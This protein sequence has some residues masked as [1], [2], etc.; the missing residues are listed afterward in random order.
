M[1]SLIEF[2][3][4][5]DTREEL[6][7]EALQGLRKEATQALTEL[8]S[9]D[10]V[11]TKVTPYA[12]QLPSALK[13]EDQS[14]QRPWSKLEASSIAHLVPIACRRAFVEAVQV[15]VIHLAETKE[16]LTSER[17][18]QLAWE[19]EN[20]IAAL[21]TFEC[22]LSRYRYLRTLVPQVVAIG[23][24]LLATIIGAWFSTT[25]GMTGNSR[26]IIFPRGPFAAPEKGVSLS[27]IPMHR[28]AF[29]RDFAYYFFTGHGRFADEYFSE[30]PKDVIK[31]N[32]KEEIAKAASDSRAAEKH[33]LQTWQLDLVNS[34]YLAS[35]FISAIEINITFKEAK[36]FPWHSINA[37]PTLEFKL[38]EVPQFV[39]PWSLDLYENL[40]DFELR[41]GGAIR[42][43]NIGEGPALGLQC[44]VVS[45]SGLLI[46]NGELD[47]LQYAD[48]L[49]TTYTDYS[50]GDRGV[51][52]TRRLNVKSGTTS[53]RTYEPNGK[54]FQRKM[55]T[56]DVW[57]VGDEFSPPLHWRKTPDGTDFEKVTTITRLKELTGVAVHEPATA[58]FT[59]HSLSGQTF[60]ERVSFDLPEWLIYYEPKDDLLWYDPSRPMPDTYV[61]EYAEEGV[62]GALSL[63]FAPKVESVGE[64][65]I[66]VDVCMDLYAIAEGSAVETAIPVNLKLKPHGHCVIGLNVIGLRTGLYEVV[67]KVNGKFSDRMTVDVLTPEAYSLDEI[68]G[69]GKVLESRI[70]RRGIAQ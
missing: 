17:R 58:E 37:S 53:V 40:S 51:A 6:L 13:E 61:R 52:G 36:E 2:L 64:D 11:K 38:V 16:E 46:S 10:R 44:K 60:L 26:Q 24:T 45:K 23:A 9:A 35:E 27:V 41:S 39:P 70:Q 59:Y 49:D 30:I 25:H 32:H 42:V 33:V 31:I 14:S 54:T 1:A 29:L 22:K 34:A 12:Y 20:D 55:V 7:K 50:F 18:K 56:N 69:G 4:N 3:A 43:K 62:D 5:K 21:T 63:L 15:L 66:K 8:R 65:I 48:E 28:Q 19:I 47:E 68:E 67:T 57:A